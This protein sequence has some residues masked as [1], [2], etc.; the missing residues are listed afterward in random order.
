MQSMVFTLYFCV[1]AIEVRRSLALALKKQCTK[2]RILISL[3]TVIPM[4][5]QEYFDCGVFEVSLLFMVAGLSALIIFSTV[6]LLSKHLR[7]STLQLVGYLIFT[8]A[9]VWLVIFLP[10]IERGKLYQQC[11]V[12]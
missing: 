12:V 6:G 3:Q 1:M 10:M 5:M 8:F 4:V 9:H 11:N 7:D 2:V